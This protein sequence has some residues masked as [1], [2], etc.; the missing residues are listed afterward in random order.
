MVWTFYGKAE[1]RFGGSA[2]EDA[3]RGESEP[4]VLAKK[5]TKEADALAGHGPGVRGGIAG[6]LQ[7]SGFGTR[8][9]S[10]FGE[11][12]FGIAGTG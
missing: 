12:N 1:W 9:H 4:T 5:E 8:G 7:T 3:R 11:R 6:L 10:R 2:S